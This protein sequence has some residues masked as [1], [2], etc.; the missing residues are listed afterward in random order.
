[1]D[2]ELISY[3]IFKPF[4]CLRS[5]TTTKNTL[6]EPFPRFSGETI[7]TTQTK[8]NLAEKSGI[9]VSQF[10]FPRQTHT[11]RVFEINRLPET[12]IMNTDALITD[13]SGICLCIQ[14]ADCVPILF[15]D[16]V[17]KVIS[18]AHAGWKGTVKNIAARVVAKMKAEYNS[19][20][21][22]ILVAIGPSISKKVY[23]IGNEVSEIVRQSVPNPEATLHKN[24]R[25]KFHFD[26]W[27]AN[28]QILLSKGIQQNNIEILGEC[29]FL[30]KEK[31]FSARRDG[32]KTGRMVS[33]MILID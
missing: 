30:L 6:D 11:N 24:P 1:M 18:V 5:F 25:G 33:G 23:E 32:K 14:T 27:E 3:K 20:P 9:P 7:N 12:E 29:S 16:P 19:E 10:I 4:N 8:L 22:K 13:K 31:Y 17:R 28:R 2:K 15:F 26:L 21:A